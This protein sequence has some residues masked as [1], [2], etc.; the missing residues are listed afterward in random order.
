MKADANLKLV[1]DTL[2]NLARTADQITETL[3]E[4]EQRQIEEY[5]A[6]THELFEKAYPLA[7]RLEAGL[8]GIGARSESSTEMKCAKVEL[9]TIPIPIFSGKISKFGI[10]L[11]LFNASLHSQRFTNLQK[12][13]HL[14]QSLKGEA[15]EAIRRY[16]VSDEN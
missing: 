4:E 2:E 14:L 6:R 7:D 15:K 8:A 13:N 10:F 1:S 12:F 9:P 5:M 3:S 16:A 11:A